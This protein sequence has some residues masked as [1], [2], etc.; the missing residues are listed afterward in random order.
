MLHKNKDTKLSPPIFYIEP[1]VVS[2]FT[3]FKSFLY[4]NLKFKRVGDLDIGLL[5]D[6]LADAYY[7]DSRYEHIFGSYWPD[8]DKFFFDNLHIANKYAFVTTL[9]NQT[10]GFI[11]WDPRQLPE[12]VEIGYNYIASK[13]KGNGYGNLQLQEEFY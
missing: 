6:L 3:N 7:F 13:Y 2:R 11:S 8:F 12:Y 10:I 1:I 4:M 5:F 9:Y